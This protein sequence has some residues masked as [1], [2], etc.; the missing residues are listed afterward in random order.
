MP[1]WRCFVTVGALCNLQ[2]PAASSGKRPGAGI[3][4][5]ALAES[6]L[7]RKMLSALF[8]RRKS[9]VAVLVLATIALATTAVCAGAAEGIV[10][11]IARFDFRDTSGE[12]GDRS[13]E[14]E[15]RI[16]DL[17][18]ALL[19]TLSANEKVRLVALTCGNEGCS[20]RTSGLEALSAEA[21]SAGASYL[22]IGEV[23]KMSTLVGWVKFAV[24]DLGQGKPVCDRFLTYRG[25]T[26]EAW[27]RA[28]QFAARD[29]E[30]HC[31]PSNP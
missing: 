13:A 26:D 7:G 1:R 30:R 9:P 23:H 17:R 15:R 24:L 3:S 6:M 11:A 4:A 27:N 22:L 5:R 20:P 8:P 29:V 31:I 18:L 21:K 10:L 16:G 28:A 25:D 2:G 12:P 19:R 14:H